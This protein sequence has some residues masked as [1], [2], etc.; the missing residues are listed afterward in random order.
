[1]YVNNMLMFIERDRHN[2][3]GQQDTLDV[4]AAKQAEYDVSRLRRLGSET[5]HL[6][7]GYEQNRLQHWPANLNFLTSASHGI[8]RSVDPLDR[9]R[10]EFDGMLPNQPVLSLAVPTELAQ[11]A[12]FT[13]PL[14]RSP[15]IEQ[16]VA[17]HARPDQMGPPQPLETIIGNQRRDPRSE[18]TSDRQNAND[19]I[20]QF[21]PSYRKLLNDQNRT[22]ILEHTSPRTGD[23]FARLL[24]DTRTSDRIR[25][26][27]ATN[28]DDRQLPPEVL[29]NYEKNRDMRSLLGSYQGLLPEGMKSSELALARTERRLRKATSAQVPPAFPRT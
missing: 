21:A 22:A 26:Q 7:A 6:T 11:Y 2:S 15:E 17:V 14:A 1:M 25:A 28:R 3:H 23:E 29:Q 12:N 10:R 19:L 4:A 13:M 18:N 5:R 24:A 20:A 27:A 9:G 16:T 8:D